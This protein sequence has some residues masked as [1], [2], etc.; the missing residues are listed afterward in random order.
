MAPSSTAESRLERLLDLHRALADVSREIGPGLELDHVLR[1]VLAAMR[2]LL[3]FKG[4]SICLVEGNA[5]RLAVSEPEVSDDVKAARLPLGQGLSG[6][7]VRNRKAIRVD[8]ITTDERAALTTL[9]SN[10]TIRSYLAVP[11]VCLGEVIGLLQVDSR[12]IG[13]F[14]NDDLIVLE[15]LGTQVAGVIESARRYEEMVRL[16]HLKDDFIERVSH[17][18]RTPVTIL[19]GFATTLA[20]HRHRL[21]DDERGQYLDRIAAASERLHYLIEEILT[22][23]SLD[24]GLTSPQ[25]ELVPLVPFLEAIATE[26]PGRVEVEATDGNNVSVVSDQSVLRNILVP[27]IDNALKYAGD[28]TLSAERVEGGV[29]IRVRDSGPGV[30]LELRDKL[31]ERFTRG[32]HTAHGMGLGLAIADNLAATIGGTV[33]YEPGDP[34]SIFVIEVPDFHTMVDH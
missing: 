17:E 15:G 19:S 33:R 18:L 5:I 22:L 20:S 7:V 11:L 14:T 25:P 3:E 30:E 10:A 23:S 29:V 21:S 34:G 2:R 27:L 31:F 24:S 8:D 6:W 28:A 13:A 26:E 4:G 16:Q 1:T 32:R 12:E 9:G